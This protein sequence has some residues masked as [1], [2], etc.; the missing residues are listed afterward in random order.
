MHFYCVL[1]SKF[2][3]F[4][5]IYKKFKAR[6]S[7]SIRIRII[8]KDGIRI[9]N[10]ACNTDV[11]MIFYIGSQQHTE[12]VSFVST[13]FFYGGRGDILYSINITLEF[14]SC[15]NSSVQMMTVHFLIALHTLNYT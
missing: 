9:R 11:L 10:T 2:D 8:A 15:Y 13:D 1:N 3:K 4:Y 12:T 7:D 6:D 5:E 14:F